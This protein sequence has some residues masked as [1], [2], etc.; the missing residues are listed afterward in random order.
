MKSDFSQLME[1]IME[2]VNVKSVRNR[3][4]ENVF[5]VYDGE[6]AWIEIDGERKEISEKNKKKF[7]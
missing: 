4:S 5:L 6:D 2:E 3:I 7:L 1:I